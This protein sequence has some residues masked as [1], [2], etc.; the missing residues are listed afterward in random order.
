MK[1]LFR[2]NNL[3]NGLQIASKAV[4]THT[5]MPILQCIL[6]TAKDHAITLT[7]NDMDMGIETNIEGEI[8]EDGMKYT[9]KVEERII[10]KDE[11]T[12]EYCDI[13]STKSAVIS[14]IRILL[15]TF[16]F[17]VISK[18]YFQHLKI[19]TVVSIFPI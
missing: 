3:L 19:N 12:K 16:L 6:I 15:I 1:L 17:F 4:P 5:T 7:A 13:I 2:K 18:Q 14:N 11:K 8:I 10:T 9:V